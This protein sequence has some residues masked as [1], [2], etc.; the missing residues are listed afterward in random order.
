M[1]RLILDRSVAPDPLRV[2]AADSTGQRKSLGELLRWCHMSQ[3]LAWSTVETSCDP[4]EVFSAMQS[5]T[6][7][8]WLF[9]GGRTIPLTWTVDFFRDRRNRLDSPPLLHALLHDVGA[10]RPPPD[11][12]SHPGVSCCGNRVL[13]PPWMPPREGRSAL[14]H[15]SLGWVNP[16]GSSGLARQALSSPISL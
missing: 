16:H 14:A 15:I 8:S 9:T 1:P 11:A 12:L 6:P 5:S 4:A 13:G 7:S 10:A 2:S 3:G